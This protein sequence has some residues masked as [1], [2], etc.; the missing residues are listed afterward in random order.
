M[1]HTELLCRLPYDSLFIFL[2]SWL[3]MSMHGLT[4]MYEYDIKIASIVRVLEKQSTCLA[5]VL[6][7]R[8]KYTTF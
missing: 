7:Y 1:L 6:F 2:F 4:H 3:L 8:F 5:A